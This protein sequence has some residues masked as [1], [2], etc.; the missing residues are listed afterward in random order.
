M[1]R[2]Q[3]LQFIVFTDCLTRIKTKRDQMS[4]IF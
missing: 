4:S 1:E 2:D 3:E